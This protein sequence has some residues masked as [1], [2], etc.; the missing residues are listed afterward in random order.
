MFGRKPPQDEADTAPQEGGVLPLKKTRQ[1]A[2]S[3]ELAKRRDDDRQNGGKSAM[4]AEAKTLVIGREIN[5]KGEIGDCDTLM[6]HGSA[7]AV[8]TN[9]KSFHI[10]QSGLLSGTAEVQQAEVE[11][12]FEGEL[13]VRGKLV[14]RS[15]G[16][17]RGKISYAEIEVEPGGRIDGEITSIEPEVVRSRAAG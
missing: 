6:V 1:T 13:T 11:G 7:D 15:G 3:P 16:R 2:F 8:L 9:C 12:R 10:T 4:T 14:I 5:L 17:V